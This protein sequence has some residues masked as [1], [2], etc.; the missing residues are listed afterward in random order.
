MEIKLKD[1]VRS[2]SNGKEG[3]V[4]EVS[5]DG[6]AILMDDG[7]VMRPKPKNFEKWF[8]KLHVYDIR[9][10]Y[11]E[12]GAIGKSE[13]HWHEVYSI[14]PKLAKEELNIWLYQHGFNHI[15]CLDVWE[16]G[17]QLDMMK[18]LELE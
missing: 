17:V 9:M 3:V 11:K 18:V 2:L 1:K 4:F 16:D 6:I 5:Q 7:S 8:A 13:Y 12:R 15:L 14:S 10:S